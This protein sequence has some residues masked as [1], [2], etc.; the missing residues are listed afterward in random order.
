MARQIVLAVLLLASAGAAPVP[1]YFPLQ[2]GNQ[3]IYRAAG[4][5]GVEP[6]SVEIPQAGYFDGRGYVLLR[7]L[8]EGDAWLRLSEAGT[9]YRYDPETGRE[10]VWLEFGAPAGQPFATA[11]HPCNPA[12][13]IAS[14]AAKW[15]GPVGEFDTALE[16]QYQPGRCADAGLERD[17]YL[18]YVGLVERAVTTIAGPRRY[19]LVYAR[20]GGVTFVTAPEVSVS[21]ALDRYLYTPGEQPAE[22]LARLTLRNSRLEPLT[23]NFGSS[24]R[25]DLAIRDGEGREVYRWSEGKAFLMVFGSEQVG[26]GERN[27]A[28]L[29]PLATRSGA[30]L[31]PGHY[32]VEAWLTNIA[33]PRLEAKAGLEIRSR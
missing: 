28:V 9:L 17:Y 30:P 3:W 23:L 31:P 4:S 19:Q 2:V 20:L 11:I 22:L 25:F 27:Y 24:Q 13:V 10:E 5:A 1:D 26:T 12:A 33:P 7:G 18:P 8:P 6:L 15:E 16:V 21:L 14:R 29:V 32:S